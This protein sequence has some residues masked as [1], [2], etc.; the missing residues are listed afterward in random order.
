MVSEYISILDKREE[1]IV[2]K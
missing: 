1:P 2:N